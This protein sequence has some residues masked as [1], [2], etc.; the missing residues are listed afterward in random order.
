M[1]NDPAGNPL[2]AALTF[3][4]HPSQPNK[5]LVGN[6]AAGLS[7]W[8]YTTMTG[9]VV[10]YVKQIDLLGCYSSST[11]VASTAN[12]TNTVFNFNPINLP[13][14]TANSIF[15]RTVSYPE[16]KAMYVSKVLDCVFLLESAQ[17][18][19]TKA[20]TLSSQ[21]YAWPSTKFAS[22]M[23][24]CSGTTC[25][26]SIGDHIYPRVKAVNSSEIGRAHV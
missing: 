14:I 18:T 16:I 20:T 3:D 17:V 4:V 6:S 26:A 13:T 15:Y 1:V 9:S 22:L 7:I 10:S 5:Y 23:G 21:F 2:V 12:G 8:D 11:C 19:I 24:Y 25:Y